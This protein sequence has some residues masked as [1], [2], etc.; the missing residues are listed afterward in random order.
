MNRAGEGADATTQGTE[1]EHAIASQPAELE[2]VAG[3]DLAPVARRLEG[4]R[5]VW[6]VGTGSSQHVAELGATLLA[7]AGLDA[8]WSGSAD[9]A[10]G[11]TQPQR[12]DAVI[13]ISHTG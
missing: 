11:P 4:R 3:Y 13:L 8:R 10:R 2:R 5:W 1:L 12:G 6:L 9:F 7:S